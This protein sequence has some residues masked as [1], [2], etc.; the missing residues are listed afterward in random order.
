MMLT[1]LRR[2]GFNSDIAHIAAMGSIVASIAA[3]AASRKLEDAPAA[4]AERWGIYVGLWA[5][6]FLGLANAL[7]VDEEAHPELTHEAANR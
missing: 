7:K 2:A 6:T 1:V 4:K 5:P 3:W